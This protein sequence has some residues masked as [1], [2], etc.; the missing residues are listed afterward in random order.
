MSALKLKTNR[1]LFKRVKDLSLLLDSKDFIKVESAL[2]ALKALNAR[3]RR[4]KPKA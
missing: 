1:N 2:K 3:R 4:R